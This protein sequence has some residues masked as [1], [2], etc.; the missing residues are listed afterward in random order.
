[1]KSRRR[2]NPNRCPSLSRRPADLGKTTYLTPR[3]GATVFPGAKGTEINEITDGTTNTI[4]VVDASDDLAVTWTEPRDWEVEP[5]LAV[6]GLFGHHPEGTNFCFADGSVRLV[7]E[8][9]RLDV[10]TALL[11]RNGGEVLNADAF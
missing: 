1:M 11:T 4:L 8:T 6:K 3:G 9:I 5:E 2:R 10:L 7:K